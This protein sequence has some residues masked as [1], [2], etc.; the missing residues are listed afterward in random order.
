MSFITAV[1]LARA[2][3]I[4]NLLPP[5]PSKVAVLVITPELLRSFFIKY[6]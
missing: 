3:E 6:I 1:R 5:L 2:L 4:L